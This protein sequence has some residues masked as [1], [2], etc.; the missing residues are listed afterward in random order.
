MTLIG[1]TADKLVDYALDMMRKAGE[2][3][4]ELTPMARD[5]LITF[6][7]DIYFKEETNGTIASMESHK[8]IVLNIKA[9][10]LGYLSNDVTLYR[11][12]K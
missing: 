12:G 10:V 2:I 9:F 3:V 8:D 1:L 5:N 11:V 7:A 6:I 4:V